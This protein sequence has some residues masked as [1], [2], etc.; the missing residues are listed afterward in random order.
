MIID[1]IDVPIVLAP[2]AGGPST[3]ELTAAVAEAGGLGMLAAGYLAATALAERIAATRTATAKPF[4]VNLFVPSAPTPPAA[5][6]GYLDRLRARFPVG[7]PT[8]DT[9]DWDAKLD[10]L[11][12]DPVAV[13]SFAFGCP[14]AADVTRLHAVGSEVWVTVTSPAEAAIA[15]DAGADVLIAQGA[16]AGGHRATFVDRSTDDAADPLGL[17]ALLQLLTASTDRPIVAAGGI[18]TGAGIAAALAAGASAAQLG[19]AFLRCPEA[20][21]NQLL[22]DAVGTDTPTML[23]RAFTGRRARGLRNR[24]LTDFTADAPVA[25]PEIHYATAPLRAAARAEGDAD[26]VNLWAGQAHSLTRQL[27]AGE[28]VATLATETKTALE[29]ALSRRIQSC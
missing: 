26:A 8:H 12:A 7:E 20:G 22:R 16:E 17:L 28:L 24:F 1:D 4:G 29:S 13:V 9:D 25:Y 19:T 27:P 3:P 18:A 15:V 5:F 6:A 14:S 11:T 2:M 21:T 23:T 10:L